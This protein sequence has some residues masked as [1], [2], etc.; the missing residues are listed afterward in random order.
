MS[1]LMKIF[2]GSTSSADVTTALEKARADQVAAD[3][4]VAATDEAYQDG[5][6][7]ETPAALRKLV[8]AKSEATVSADI[9]RAKVDRLEADLEAALTSE[10]DEANRAAYEKAKSLAEAAK[11][12][13]HAEYPRLALGIREIIRA[14]AE[15]DVAV[16]A[17]NENRPDGEP[18]LL[19]PESDRSTP[20]LWREVLSEDRVEMWAPVNQSAPI[21][22]DL[23]R[24]VRPYEQ[25]RR[26]G[27]RYEE[28]DNDAPTQGTVQTEHGSLE[29]VRRTFLRRKILPDQT[30]WRA[31]SLASELT[32]PAL[33]AG[34]EAVWSP[35]QGGAS[36]VLAS[37]VKPLRQRPV[38][39]AREPIFEYSPL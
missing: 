39:A 22:E 25:R 14:A 36:T 18:M 3:A 11:K 7:T 15:A 31:A 1:K 34:D 10:A 37:A 35:S 20:T 9:A 12:K 16:A 2:S 23:Q 21:S 32:L 29:V 24:K 30:G 13:L 33:L 4:V 38:Q 8:D 6:L 5:L 19:G 28:A 17:A 26:L 27:S